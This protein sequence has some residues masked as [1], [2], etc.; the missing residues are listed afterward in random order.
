MKPRSRAQEHEEHEY[1]TKSKLHETKDLFP[2]FS[3]PQRLHMSPLWSSQR[4]RSLS[5]LILP[6]CHQGKPGAHYQSSRRGGQYKLPGTQPQSL[7]ALGRYLAIK[8]I[9]S[10]RVKNTTRSLRERVRC[11]CL[12]QWHTQ[13]S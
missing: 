6:S 4:V 5:T 1:A 11:S 3:K 7:G 10:P 12:N 9:E 2:K 8:G 13:G